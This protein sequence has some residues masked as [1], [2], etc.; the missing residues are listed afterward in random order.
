MPDGFE[1]LRNGVLLAELAGYGDGPYCA[2]HGAGCALVVMG[3]YI[4]DAGDSVA[5]PSHF[6]FKPGRDSY[7]GYLQEHVAAAREGGAAVGVSV[8]TV[9][10]DDSIDF[11]LASEEAGADYV[12]LCLHS[13]MEMFVSVGLSTELLRR[14]NWS[15]LREHVGKCVAAL[16]RPFIVKMRMAAT[17]D[18]E[19]AVAELVDSGVE[20]IHANVGDA[21]E[22]SGL[23]LIERLKTR[24]P[25]VIAGGKIGTIEDARRAIAAGADAVALGTAAMQDPGLCGR[26]QAALRSAN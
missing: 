20:L 2:K 8:V 23:E 17:P 19:G 18:A 21:T 3:T 9:D 10:L 6:V 15:R 26:M 4:V 12:S 22:A 1:Q 7:A 13:V 24:A 11:L 25:F 16:S 14:G 5:Y